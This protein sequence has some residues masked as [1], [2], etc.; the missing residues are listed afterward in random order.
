MRRFLLGVVI[1]SATAAM[2]LE[3]HGGDREIAKN[4]MTELQQFQDAGQLKGFD[5]NMKVEDGVVYLTGEVATSRQRSMIVRSAAKAAGSENVVNEIQIRSSQQEATDVLPASGSEQ[6]DTPSDQDRAI[7]DAIYE[8][9]AEAKQAGKLRGFNLDISTVR[10][11]VWVRG[12]VT[13]DR[14]KA[15]VLDI[16]RRTRGVVQ[17]IDDLSV[18]GK[19]GVRPASNEMS[20]PPPMPVPPVPQTGL[21]GSSMPVM[22]R[23]SQTGPRAFAPSSSASYSSCPD[24]AGCA[25]GVGGAGGMGGVGGPMPLNHAGAEFGA[26][27]PRYDQPNLPNYSWP[28]YAAYPNYAAVTYPKQYSP[29]AWPYIGP[30]YPYPQVPLGWRQVTLQWDD[31]LWYLDFTSKPV[32]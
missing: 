27:A 16:A 4:V 23:S 9:L 26:G 19:N 7:T 30:F 2:P 31:G 3:A 5:I 18:A 24:A 29:S 22:G 1:A 20:L 15:M 28:S 11:D 12:H 14:T 13:S 8:R 25:G 17:V 10:G 21:Q 32:R 6:S